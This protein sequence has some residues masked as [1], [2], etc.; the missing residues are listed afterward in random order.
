MVEK[1]GVSIV[2]GFIYTTN[3][4][5]ALLDWVVSNPNYKEKD[6][7]SA[8]EKLLIDAE[9][10]IKK[11]G[12]KYIFSIGRSKHLINTHK[13]LGWFVDDKPSHEILKNL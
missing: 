1:E 3:S 9:N 6:R 2:A 11:M 7:Q 4:G 10:K 5:V 8:I 13:K 12:Y